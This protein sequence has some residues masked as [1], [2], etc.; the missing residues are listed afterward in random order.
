MG[1]SNGSLLLRVAWQKESEQK[2]RKKKDKQVGKEKCQRFKLDIKTHKSP[3]TCDQH[4]NTNLKDITGGHCIRGNLIY[5]IVKRYLFI[6]TYNPA[7]MFH[8]T[9]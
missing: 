3:Y 5:E 7:G 1:Q 8:N 2:K 9:I 4:Q 6:I